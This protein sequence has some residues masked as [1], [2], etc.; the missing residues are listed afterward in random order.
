M[1]I[2]RARL[3]GVADC[4]FIDLQVG[5]Q[6]SYNSWFSFGGLVSK[7]YYPEDSYKNAY[8]RFSPYVSF[9]LTGKSNKKSLLRVR[10]GKE[11]IKYNDTSGVKLDLVIDQYLF[12]GVS[13]G[14]H[15]EA[16]GINLIYE[17]SPEDYSYQY[18]LGYKYLPEED[19]LR[20]DALQLFFRL[21]VL[22]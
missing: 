19:G 1:I 5:V 15:N 10:K 8:S 14:Y 6:R 11:T 7:G 13:N 12:H 16:Y 4:D 2:H 20:M 9:S 18:G 21:G 17:H 22:P 3:Y